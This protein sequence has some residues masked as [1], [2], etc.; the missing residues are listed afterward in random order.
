MNTFQLLWIWL[1]SIWYSL[2]NKRKT[3]IFDDFRLLWAFFWQFLTRFSEMTEFNQ[4]TFSET[5]L[6]SNIFR[7]R[8]KQAF[9]DA[10]F[11]QNEFLTELNLAVSGVHFSFAT[12]FQNLKFVRFCSYSKL[13]FSYDCSLQWFKSFVDI[14]F[15]LREIS[16]QTL[17]NLK[18]LSLTLS[19][20]SVNM[21]IRGKVAAVRV[22][23]IHCK[24]TS[25][26]FLLFL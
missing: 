11:G 20:D 13:K 26:V 4:F 7:L 10:W 25:I 22:V 18:K 1:V 6:H 19:S 23:E 21:P 15:H 9:F 16:K 2:T 12:I 3:A 17:G 8:L 14:F 24:S 5:L